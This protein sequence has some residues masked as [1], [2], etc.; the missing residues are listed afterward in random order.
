MIQHLRPLRT[1]M[2]I[3]GKWHLLLKVYYVV[4]YAETV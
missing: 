3:A 2:I 4:E 1:V